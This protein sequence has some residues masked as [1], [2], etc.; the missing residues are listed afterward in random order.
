MGIPRCKHKYRSPRSTGV[1]QTPVWRQEV[2]QLAP[3]LEASASGNQRVDHL[4]LDCLGGVD[5]RRAVD[6]DRKDEM[7]APARLAVARQR[8]DPPGWERAGL[9][10]AAS[11]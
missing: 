8:A 7:V 9:R 6:E 11:G 2:G 3:G 5:T 1:M 10:L 4:I